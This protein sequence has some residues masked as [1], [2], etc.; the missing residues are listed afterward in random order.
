MELN[1]IR[2]VEGESSA[3]KLDHSMDG[4]L[5][6]ITQKQEEEARKIEDLLA[7]RRLA[8][9]KKQQDYLDT[10]YCN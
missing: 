10:V 6:R 8:R 3:N 4:R 9:A 2:R 5:A 1:S 7:K